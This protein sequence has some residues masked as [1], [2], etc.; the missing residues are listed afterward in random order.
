[1]LP[2]GTVGVTYYDFRNN[3]TGD[4]STD[5]LETDYFMVHCHAADVDCTNAANWSETQITGSS[6]DMRKAPDAVGYF[7]GDYEGLT[8]TTISSVDSFLAFFSQS[9]ST[10]DPA[11]VYASNIGP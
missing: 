3:G 1:V 10:S 6:F 2:D 5:P 11:T 9:N 8:N 7:T 4:T